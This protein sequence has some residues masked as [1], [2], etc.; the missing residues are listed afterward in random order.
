MEPFSACP[1]TL[2]WVPSREG[3]VIDDVQVHHTGARGI[4]ILPVRGDA[5]EAVSRDTLAVH[6]SAKGEEAEFAPVLDGYIVTS[7][8][9]TRA[10]VSGPGGS[11]VVKDGQTVVLAGA[12]WTVKII[13]AGVELLGEFD[14]V[15][16]V[17]DKSLRA[18]RFSS[19]SGDSNSSDDDTSSD[20]DDN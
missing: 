15:L 8:A 13:P 2:N 20:D 6:K 4:L 19:S 11:Q 10:V 9:S 5:E 14:E 7:H 18:N 3:E 12:S 17:F 16:L 1:L